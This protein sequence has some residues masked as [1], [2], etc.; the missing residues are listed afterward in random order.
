[1]IDGTLSLWT[2]YDNPSDMPGMF[3]ARRFDIGRGEAVWTDICVIA[4]TLDGVREL[5]PQGLHCMP[6][7]DGDEPQIVETWI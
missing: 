6:R 1:M 5:I 7:A 4:S 3:V 2:V